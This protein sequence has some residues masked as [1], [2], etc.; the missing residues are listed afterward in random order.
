MV[1]A[2]II[3]TKEDVLF[4]RK[5]VKVEIDL[6]SATTPSREQVKEIVAK[7]SKAN[8]SLILVQ[9]VEKAYGKTQ[10]IVTAKIYLDKSS[11]EKT[12]PE[13]MLKRNKIEKSKEDKKEDSS[14]DESKV[15]EK[16][17]STADKTKGE[18]SIKGE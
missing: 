4:K 13:Y 11:L 9:S 15:E 6:G 10:A 14:K 8:S 17:N 5:I 7:L 1:D 3:D 2:K 16:S 12:E 18:G